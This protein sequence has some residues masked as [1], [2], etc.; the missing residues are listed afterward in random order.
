MMFVTSVM[1]N[2]RDAH[3]GDV[4]HVRDVERIETGDRRG[5][6]LKF[7]PQGLTVYESR[8]RAA[9]LTKRWCTPC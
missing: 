9:K 8:L 7:I 2:V 3:A 6:N 4:R 1:H 5:E